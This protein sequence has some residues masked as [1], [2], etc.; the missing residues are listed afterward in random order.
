M[1]LTTTVPSSNLPVLID[2]HSKVVLLG[3][4]FTENIG[5]KLAYFGF[6]VTVNPFGIVFNSTSLRILVERAINNQAFTA[7][8]GTDHFSYL[9]HSDLNSSDPKKLISNLNTALQ[10]LRESLKEA[11]HL[12]ITLG[13]SWVYRYVEKDMIVANCHKQPQELFRKELLPIDGMHDDLKRIYE[14]VTN[15]NKE[16]NITYTLSPVRHIKDGFVENQRSKARLHEAIQLHVE[17]TN[18]HYFPAYEIAMDELR[19]YRFYARD[20]VHLNDLGIDFIWIRFRESAINTN[21]LPQ[22]QAVEKYRKLSHH[23]STDLELHEQHL[24]KMR[25]QIR[26]Q[27]PLIN[28]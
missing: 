7:A 13:T 2:Q 18:A 1:K 27:Y 23:K 11:T 28:L 16:I 21:T 4:C 3:S 9:V 10:H 26:T 17:R 8:D 14:L 24:A 5:S 12:F 6:D 25:E 22:Q 15:W 19:D 20:M